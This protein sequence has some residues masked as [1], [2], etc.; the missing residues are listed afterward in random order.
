MGRMLMCERTTLSKMRMA[1]M[2]TDCWERVAE[3]DYWDHIIFLW[4]TDGS[5]STKGI[6]LQSQISFGVR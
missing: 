3:W 4:R 6:L 5:K 1:L 2:Q